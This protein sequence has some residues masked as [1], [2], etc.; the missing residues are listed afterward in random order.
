MLKELYDR[1][2]KLEEKIEN[3]YN[4]EDE[5]LYGTISNYYDKMYKELEDE[6]SEVI[7]EIKYFEFY[8]RT[9]L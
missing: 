5:V 7:E 1:K 4:I 9:E 8:K 6:L 3:F 2:Y